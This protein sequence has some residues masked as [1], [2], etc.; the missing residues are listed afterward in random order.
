MTA[1]NHRNSV[2]LIAGGCRLAEWDSALGVL[3]KPSGCLR[4]LHLLN[5]RRNLSITEIMQECG[6]SQDNAY[7]SLR[8]L[9]ILGLVEGPDSSPLSKKRRIYFATRNGRIVMKYLKVLVCSAQYALRK[10]DI[11]PL[12]SMP[13]GSFD[14]ILWIHDE[15]ELSFTEILENGKCKKT[16][17][18]VLS[19]LEQLKL[20]KA[21]HSQKGRTKPY[22]LTKRGGHLALILELM[23]NHLEEL[24][25]F[26]AFTFG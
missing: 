21:T 11:L 18:S 15:G 8:H 22:S 16:T 10:D 17:Q 2:I 4:I 7:S 20:V 9:R 3:E 12:L 19:T 5:L 24:L 25:S 13:C 14:I 6:I 23:N 26:K 1:M